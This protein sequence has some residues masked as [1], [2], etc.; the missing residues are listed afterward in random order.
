MTTW[1]IALVITLVL[2]VLAAMFYDHPWV[3][4]WV[5]GFGGE[6]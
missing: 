3:E 2:M 6:R 1:I 4:A 5:E